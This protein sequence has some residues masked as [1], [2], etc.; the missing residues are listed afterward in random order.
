MYLYDPFPVPSPD[1]ALPAPTNLAIKTDQ[2]SKL[3]HLSWSAPANIAIDP[4]Q[5]KVT[6][7]AAPDSFVSFPTD[8]ILTTYNN[9]TIDLSSYYVNQQYTVTVTTVTHCASTLGHN[10]ISD[11]FILQSC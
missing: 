8:S 7:T 2:I 9:I 6:V 11:T 1:P 5:F 4:L 3:L 10:L